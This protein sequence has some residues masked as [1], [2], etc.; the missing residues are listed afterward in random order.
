M[1]VGRA[2]RPVPGHRSSAEVREE[3]SDK[4]AAE[5]ET[6]TEKTFP[7]RVAFVRGTWNNARRFARECWTGTKTLQGW[8]VWEICSLEEFEEHKKKHPDFKELPTWTQ[9]THDEEKVLVRLTATPPEFTKSAK[10]IKH[11]LLAKKHTNLCNT[12][13]KNEA[14]RSLWRK[15]LMNLPQP[16]PATTTTTTTTAAVNQ[17]PNANLQPSAKPRPNASV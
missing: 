6:K 13:K 16:A 3:R 15:K 1:P 4:L 9:E 12:S 17:R 8:S 2:G 7:N 11:F 14:I 10:R 5:L